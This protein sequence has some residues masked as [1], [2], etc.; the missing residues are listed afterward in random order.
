MDSY[1]KDLDKGP[2]RD[3]AYVY[4]PALPRTFFFNIE[5]SF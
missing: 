4:G 1:Q 5:T 3:S 2:D